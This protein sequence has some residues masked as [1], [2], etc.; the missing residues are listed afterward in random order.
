MHAEAQWDDKHDVDAQFGM[1]HTKNKSREKS[2]NRRQSHNRSLY[3]ANTLLS[4]KK[5]LKAELSNSV[6]SIV[7]KEGGG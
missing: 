5:I 6:T 4:K 3:I 2:E 1:T 7:R